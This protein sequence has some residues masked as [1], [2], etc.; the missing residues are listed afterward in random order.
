MGGQR[1]RLGKVKLPLQEEEQEEVTQEKR[2]AR[3]LTELRERPSLRG[4]GEEDRCR[5]RGRRRRP[6]PPRPLGGQREERRAV[7]ARVQPLLTLCPA[8]SFCLAP[9]ASACPASE[10]SAGL[11]NGLCKM[12]YS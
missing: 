2:T 9:P 1:R 4:E 12:F 5:L 11:C 3:S 7:S 8:S 10:D 6:Q